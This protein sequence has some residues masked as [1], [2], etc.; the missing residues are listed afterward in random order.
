MLMDGEDPDEIARNFQAVRAITVH[1]L[2]N[3][4]PFSC[5]YPYVQECI[6]SFLMRRFFQTKI[7]F[8]FLFHNENTIYVVGT[9]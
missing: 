6:D 3:Q 4:G 2:C 1:I 7:I 8:I 9:Y 5:C